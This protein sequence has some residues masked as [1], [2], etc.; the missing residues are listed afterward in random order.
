V[1]KR[2]YVKKLHERGARAELQSSSFRAVEMRSSRSL[3]YN[4]RPGRAFVFRMIAERLVPAPLMRISREAL[5]SET[6]V[7]TVTRRVQTLLLSFSSR[8]SLSDT[9]SFTYCSFNHREA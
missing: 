1:T 3:Y 5:K 2:D 7:R 6:I 4:A 9:F 8:A